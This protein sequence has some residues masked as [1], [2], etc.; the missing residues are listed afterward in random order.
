MFR[1]DIH[2]P[3]NVHQHRRVGLLEGHHDRVG[4]RC[5][6]I[7]EEAPNTKTICCRELLH[8]IEGKGNVISRERLTIIPFYILAHSERDLRIIAIPLVVSRQHGCERTIINIHKVQRLVDQALDACIGVGVKGVKTRLSEII[9]L[10]GN[11]KNSLTAGITG[12]TIAAATGREYQRKDD[13]EG[14]Y[15]GG[16]LDFHP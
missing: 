9:G 3:G 15:Q 2:M 16:R 4:V 12:G 8:H 13:Q 5:G 1:N 10:G 7:L 6:H 11:L 14:E